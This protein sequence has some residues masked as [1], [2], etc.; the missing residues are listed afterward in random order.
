MI[1]GDCGDGTRPAQRVSRVQLQRQG[2]R[3]ARTAGKIRYGKQEALSVAHYGSVRSCPSAKSIAGL[4][5]R[6]IPE[7]RHRPA[8]S[9]GLFRG[10]ASPKLADRPQC[11]ASKSRRP[12]ESGWVSAQLTSRALA[13]A[14]E[15]RTADHLVF[16][17]KNLCVGLAIRAKRRIIAGNL[18]SK[19][20]FWFRRRE[21]CKVAFVLCRISSWESETSNSRRKRAK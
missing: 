11:G 8:I 1:H 19:C 5:K 20:R 15:A 9:F 16:P 3:S 6:A 18:F 12:E 13:E 10:R 14:G 7:V 17:L 21:C 4:Q 2:C